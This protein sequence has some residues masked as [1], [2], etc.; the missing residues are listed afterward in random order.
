MYRKSIGCL[1]MMAET[2]KGSIL[3]FKNTA[4][5]DGIQSQF[6]LYEA[7]ELYRSI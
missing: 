3:L 7:T 2:F 6:Y 4:A 5:L 1:P